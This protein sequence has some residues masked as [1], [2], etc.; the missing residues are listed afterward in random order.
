M[1]WADNQDD[2]ARSYDWKG[3]R[4]QRTERQGGRVLVEYDYPNEKGEPYH[5][6]ERT[7][8]KQFLQSRW[9]PGIDGLTRGRWEYG[10]P[11]IKIPYFLPDLVEAA[12]ETPVWISE[13]EKDAETVAEFD[14]LAT[15]A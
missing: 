10:A 8:D 7:E 15:C 12:P 2:G 13:G 14:L 9:V 6:V 1:G 4:Y 11:K 5:R 3:T